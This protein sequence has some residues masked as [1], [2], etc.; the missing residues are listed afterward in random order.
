MIGAGHRARSTMPSVHLST[1]LMATPEWLLTSAASRG[2]WATLIGF[3]ARAENGG[4]IAG[5]FTWS[6]AQWTI[7]LGS[8]GSRA[9]V[10]VLVAE[11]L[12]EWSGD[13]LVVGGYPTDPE[14][15]YQAQRAAGERRAAQRAEK[16]RAADL[17]R[18]E[19]TSD[20]IGL[21]GIRS[22]PARSPARSPGGASAPDEPSGA[23]H[24]DSDNGHSGPED[25]V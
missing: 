21:D 11:L 25:A 24:A 14:R 5:A 2:Y 1:S 7:V 17:A 23:T 10:D 16:K 15:V 4:R 9:A 13:A 6:E 20:G 22:T 3:C 19:T 12:C 8:G 18:S